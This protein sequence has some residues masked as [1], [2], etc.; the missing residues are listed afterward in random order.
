MKEQINYVKLD[1]RQGQ[2][3]TLELLKNFDEMCKAIDVHYTL[4]GG[5]LLG[6]L[7]HEGFIP[8]DDDADVFLTRPD[9]DKFLAAYS[10]NIEGKEHLQLISTRHGAP[11]IPFARLVDNRTHINQKRVSSITKLWIDILPLD[12]VPEEKRLKK[13]AFWRMVR[14]CLNA[15]P[16]SGKGF[17][18]KFLRTVGS[19]VGKITLIR[20]MVCCHIDN[21]CKVKSKEETGLWC[22]L[23]AQAAIKGCI[24]E[25]T[26]NDTS[27]VCFENNY[28]EMIPDYDFYLK[29]QYGNYMEM[30]PARQR[31][32]H[33]VDL[34]I[35]YDELTDR[36]KELIGVEV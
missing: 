6:A 16:G 34:F 8:W 30:P 24:H 21:I 26:F 4:A 12:E 2:L 35:D 25:D 11:F 9:Y 10:D 3:M 36:E 28:F 7:R 17:K 32:T 27:L 15:Q 19:F 13:I 31:R 18:K 5:T 23:V 20:K 14:L 1:S 29:G 33:A 22:E